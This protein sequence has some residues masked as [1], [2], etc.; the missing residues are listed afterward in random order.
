MFRFQV[1]VLCAFFVYLL[2]FMSGCP[3]F[4]ATSTGGNPILPERMELPDPDPTQSSP[5]LLR[6]DWS[7][8]LV[9]RT[10]L[11][12][13]ALLSFRDPLL[14]SDSR[15]ER[16]LRSLERSFTADLVL[17]ILSALWC[18]LIV[19]CL[20]ALRRG[21]WFYRPML[22]MVLAPL[23]VAVLFVLLNVRRF[24]L[25]EARRNLTLYRDWLLLA[26]V[27]FEVTL[28][29][30]GG[31]VFLSRLLPERPAETMGELRFMGH[32]R[33]EGGRRRRREW[34]TTA[35]QIGAIIAAALA[36]ANVVLFPLYI[37]QIS[38]P[39]F[40]GG[41]LAAL[42]IGL[43]LFYVRAYV[44][45][46]HAQGAGGGPDSGAAFLGFRVLRNTLFV[47]GAVLVVVV[48][49]SV[50]LVITMLNIDL[51]Q[52]VELLQRPQRL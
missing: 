21:H 6:T 36:L 10:V 32:L 46:S 25:V 17:L 2:T 31:A 23:T 5:A 14:E 8:G 44:R 28:M 47:S 24:E 13:R 3:Q 52:T 37:I 27:Y 42:V 22:L 50:I 33:V 18:M 26:K 20:A 19:S 43:S 34:L 15:P 4:V 39:R 9:E 11:Q 16:L 12:R 45:V 40:F 1:A 30:A 48:A 49:V 41:L 38:F 51:L 35:A 7:A 29:F